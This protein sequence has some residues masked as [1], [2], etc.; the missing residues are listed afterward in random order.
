MPAGWTIYGAA[1]AV[2]V[3]GGALAAL[4]TD[5]PST[6]GLGA[7]LAAVVVLTAIAVAGWRQ[8]R[9]RVATSNDAVP[10]E[11]IAHEAAVEAPAAPG[12]THGEAA[13]SEPEPVAP[14]SAIAT[15][16]A[17][18]SA[19][20]PAALDEQDFPSA[21]AVRESTVLPATVVESLDAAV[22]DRVG[23]VASEPA[24]R[25]AM[26]PDAPVVEA[27]VAPAIVD[28]RPLDEDDWDG[29]ARICV[30]VT[31]AQLRWIRA[32]TFSRPWLDERVRPLVDLEPVVAALRERPFS[33]ELRTRLGTLA[34]ALSAFAAFYSDNTFPDPLLSG[35]D[36]RFFDWHEL[37]DAAPGTATDDLWSDRA[38]QMQG[39]ALALCD[40]YEVLRD[41]LMTESKVREHTDS[42]TPTRLL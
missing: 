34:A 29:L 38:A 30:A 21:P 39:L 31:G 28:S 27:P 40:A 14:E 19:G 35:T 42:G 3:L 18:E 1:C 15:A 16:A 7:A 36:W 17:V 12:G 24:A 41:S 32:D 23:G 20:G 6:L 13:A 37:T 11:H 4:A 2:G 10:A 22:A 5:G 8:R 33:V 26:V 9:P 25:E